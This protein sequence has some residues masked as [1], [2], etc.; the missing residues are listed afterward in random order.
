M[1]RQKRSYGIALCANHGSTFRVLMIKKRYTYQ[2]F[3]F[4]YGKY[5]KNDDKYIMNLFNNMTYHEKILINRL[6]FG[7]MWGLI[8]NFNPDRQMSFESGKSSKRNLNSYFRKKTK[9]ETNFLHNS[10]SRI[11]KLI[12]NSDNTESPWEVPKGHKNAGETDMDAAVREFHE[13]TNV[14]STH[15]KLHW[16]T[17]PLCESHKDQNVSYKNTYYIASDIKKHS[18]KP[19][20]S[21]QNRDQAIE[22]ESI[23]WV[24]LDELK[25]LQLN[26]KTYA[27]T[28]K[29]FK[30]IKKMYLGG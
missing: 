20:V 18:W 26:P 13:E 22:V 12:D 10:G 28:L 19:K 29:L 7:D 16:N 17:L 1:P 25:F 3:D 11:R 14:C 2:F 15:Y 21:F 30:K 8:W 6:K 27:R 24:S 23:K 4:V 9:F 5:K